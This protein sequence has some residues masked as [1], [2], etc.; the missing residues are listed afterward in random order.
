MRLE[1]ANGLLRNVGSE[2]RRMEN[3]V[4]AV[5]RLRV[6]SKRDDEDEEDDEEE[7]ALLRELLAGRKDIGWYEEGVSSA[8][9]T[10]AS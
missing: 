7:E 9:I 5:E 4:E 8:E 1:E 3:R 6:G 10:D 2:W